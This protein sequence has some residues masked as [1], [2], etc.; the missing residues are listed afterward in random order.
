M[1]QMDSIQLSDSKDENSKARGVEL[2]QFLV[3]QF[4]VLLRILVFLLFLEI[5]CWR[6]CASTRCYYVKHLCAKSLNHR[7]SHNIQRQKRI[8]KN[9]RDSFSTILVAQMFCCAKVFERI[10]HKT[11]STKPN[12]I[13]QVLHSTM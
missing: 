9:Q 1:S 8:I 4:S 7:N 5:T 2:L 10:M 13:Y 12:Q 11:F 6:V 3:A